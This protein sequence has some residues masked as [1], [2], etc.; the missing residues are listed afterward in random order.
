MRAGRVAALMIVFFWF[1]AC[2]DATEPETSQVIASRI[3]TLA[4]NL[5][6][7]VFA[8]GAG[9]SLVGV[10]AYSDYPAE[11]LKLP[12]VGDAFMVDQEQ[13]ALLQPDLLL[14]WQS[15]TPTHVVDELRRAGYRV[16]VIRTR[17][18]D[19]IATALT[20]I[21]ELTG[22]VEDA[23][24]VATA[25][26]DG[27]RSLAERNRDKTSLR[28]FY[29]VSQ[30][31][32]FTVNQEHYVSELIAICGGSNVF[33]DLN[34][35]A[36][37]VDVEAVIERNPEVMLASTDAGTQAF[38][39]WKRWPHVAANKYGNQFLMPADEIGRA[40]PRL[41]T[42]GVAVCDALDTARRRRALEDAQ[43]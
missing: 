13:L 9:A 14:V 4:P 8:A 17:S 40:T 20:R 32:L 25:Y 36:P 15:G 6:E 29:Q 21:G 5:T 43:P 37:T 26:V 42:A 33:A 39:V 18:L 23:A 11:A 28:V 10:S 27:L 34:D 24:G 30:R 22:H 16:E 7:L 19:D 12:L 31:P 1:A 3:V 38:D 41:L 35:L 2:G